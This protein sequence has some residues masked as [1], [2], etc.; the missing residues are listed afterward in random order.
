VLL[1]V[2]SCR[3]SGYPGYEGYGGYDARGYG[4]YDARGG[5]DS[6][7]CASALVGAA[8]SVLLALLF[9]WMQLLIQFACAST[10][11]NWHTSQPA[12][13]NLTAPMNLPQLML[14]VAHVCCLQWVWQLWQCLSR[15]RRGLTQLRGRRQWW[16]LRAREGRQPCSTPH[17]PIRSPL[18]AAVQLLMALAYQTACHAT[19]CNK[20]SL[21]S[22]L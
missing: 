11:V 1:H 5:Y 16:Q 20:C 12:V 10:T 9:S 2:P 6:R 18:D 22:T 19:L 4:G 13:A 15:L 3:Y 7:R 14:L 17:G 21:C 8:L